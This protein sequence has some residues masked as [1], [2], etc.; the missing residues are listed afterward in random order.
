[1][2]KL[3]KTDFLQFLSCPEELWLSKNMEAGNNRPSIDE[4]HLMEQGQLI[5]ELAKSFFT[6]YFLQNFQ[7][8]DLELAF[9]KTAEANGYLARA[10]VLSI[11][12][13]SRSIEM[14][15]VKASTRVK[16]EHIPD[17]AFQKMVF[18]DSGWTVKKCFLVYVNNA[19]QLEEDLDL[20]ELFVIEEITE[21]VNIWYPEVRDQASRALQFINGPEPEKRFTLGCSNKL[22]CAFVQHHF[23]NLP[24]HTIFDISRMGKKKL[25]KLLEANVLDIRDVPADFKLTRKQRMQVELAQKNEVVIKKHAISEELKKLK[26]PLYFLDYETFAYAVPLQKGHRPF[27]QM[28]FQYS[29]H[30]V[31]APDEEAGHFEYLLSSKQ[32]PVSQLLASLKS[33]L[34][35]TEGTVL[36]WNKGFEQSRNKECASLFPDYAEFLFSVNDRVYDLMDIFKK[37]YY[38]HPAFKGKTSLKRVLPVLCPELSYQTLPIQNGTEANIKWH[39]WTDGAFQEE[40]HEFIRKALLEYCKLDTWAMVRIWQELRC[41]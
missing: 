2:H 12:K 29:L 3:T 4:Q 1:M 5:D 13:D 14:Y 15:E 36:V 17:V 22:K 11:H 41:L 26:Y 6:K 28:L 35:P 7:K 10:D 20:Q 16:S 24:D 8:N 19:Y 23:S 31:E 32:E 21:R 9:Q 34:H 40:E 39:H 30:V 33:H 18:E 38:L 25:E 27:Q 37:E